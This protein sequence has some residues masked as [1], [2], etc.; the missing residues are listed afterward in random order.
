VPSV[1]AAPEPA[2]DEGTS[3]RIAA[4]MLSYSAIE[5]R[6]GW[7]TLPANA[8]LTPGVASPEVALLRQ[9]LEMTDD[10]PSQQASGE[11]YDEAVAAGVRRFQFRHGLEQTGAIGPKTLA[12]L[13]VPARN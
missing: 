5:V 8:K 11:M 4:A 3:M 2:F 9:R 6:G 7:P 10:L 13:N 12:A 1:A